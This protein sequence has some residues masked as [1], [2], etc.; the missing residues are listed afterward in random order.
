[1]NA[2][3]DRQGLVVI[4]AGVTASSIYILVHCIFND[5]MY[6]VHFHSRIHCENVSSTS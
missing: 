4:V 2:R 6:P 1:M 3:V 5:H